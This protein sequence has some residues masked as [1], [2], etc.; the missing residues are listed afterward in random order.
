MFQSV[1]REVFQ[2]HMPKEIPCM[3]AKISRVEVKLIAVQP[4]G[5][6]ERPCLRHNALIHCISRL[7]E[8]SMSVFTFVRSRN[9][10]KHEGEVSSTEKLV[11]N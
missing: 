10:V 11:L 9:K 3:I 1:V 2:S 8:L 4:L 5:W 7:P 6:K